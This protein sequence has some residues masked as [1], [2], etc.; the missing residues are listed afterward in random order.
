MIELKNPDIS[1]FLVFCMT[2]GHFSKNTQNRGRLSVEI[3]K[4]DVDILYK[5]QSM[6][7][8]IT[9]ISNR[10]RNTNFKDNYE[11]AT[12]TIY[13]KNFRDSLIDI[14]FEY[15]KK[16]FFMPEEVSIRDF[17]RGIIEAYGSIG[18]MKSNRPFISLVVSDENMKN[19]YLKI[20][21]SL[22]GKTKQI[23]RNT[24]DSVYN[25]MLTDED[26]QKMINYLYY[27]DCLSIN[28]K[29][30]LSKAVLTWIRTSKKREWEHKRWTKEEDLFILS[31]SVEESMK[32]L[33]RTKKKY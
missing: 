8:D 2:D 33:N 6:F 5:F 30:E 7:S 10:I 9:K 15:G 1:Y 17:W 28:R 27:D 12:F 22:T 20:I 18:F 4:R 11:S 23:N 26:A 32:E 14:G 29:Y 31:H 24:R 21:E 13:D 16:K 25:I 3:S 19:E